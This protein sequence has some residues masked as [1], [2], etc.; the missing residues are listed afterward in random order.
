CTLGRSEPLD[1]QAAVAAAKA[2][3]P[4]LPVVTIGTSL[5]GAAVLR[6]A[7]TFGGIAGVVAVSAPGWWRELDTDGAR[8]I[9]RWV[10][11]PAG[12]MVLASVL[13][14]RVAGD[15]GDRP[16]PSDTVARIAPAF[17]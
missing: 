2:A 17:K 6:H 12:R 5:G 9:R 13:R 4:G 3:H 15:F 8:R 16:D 7:A 14:T 1:V 10:Q 11:G